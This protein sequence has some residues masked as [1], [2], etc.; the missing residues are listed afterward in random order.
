MCYVAGMR[1]ILVLGAALLLGGCVYYPYTGLWRPA[2]YYG[3]YG[4]GYRP[5]YRSRYYG[6]PYYGYYGSQYG[7]SPQYGYSP[8]PSGY[9]GSPQPAGPM[10]GEPLT[11]QQGQP[12][13]EQPPPPGGGPTVLAPPRGG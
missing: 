11:T 1:C 5:Y 10:Q 9:Q 3:Y 12:Q 2:G 8:P 13:E 4:Y 7:G 6:S